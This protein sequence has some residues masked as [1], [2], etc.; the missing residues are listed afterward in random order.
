MPKRRY[1]NNEELN[2]ELTQVG[3]SDDLPPDDFESEY[4]VQEL[5][6]DDDYGSDELDPDFA[7]AND[8]D[9]D[10]TDE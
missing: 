10:N 6:F 3:Q 1:N 4:E 5:N 8:L 9:E 2:Q 7:E